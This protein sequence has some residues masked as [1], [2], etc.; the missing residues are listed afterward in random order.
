M[1]NDHC[2]SSPALLSNKGTLDVEFQEGQTAFGIKPEFEK[3]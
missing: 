3:A 1:G 2:H